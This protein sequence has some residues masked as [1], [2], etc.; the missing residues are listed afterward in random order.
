MLWKR[1]VVLVL[2]SMDLWTKW[3]CLKVI[4]SIDLGDLVLLCKLGVFIP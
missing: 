2:G 3:L 4:S 1:F